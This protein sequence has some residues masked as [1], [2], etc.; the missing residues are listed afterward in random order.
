M[1]KKLKVSYSSFSSVIIKKKFFLKQH[2]VFQNFFSYIKIAT[3]ILVKYCQI[4]K[5][6]IFVITND[7]LVL[8]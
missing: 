1:K 6:K 4:I 5:T 7:R 2:M 3:L 8:L